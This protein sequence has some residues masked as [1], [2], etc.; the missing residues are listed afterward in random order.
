MLKNPLFSCPVH[1]SS[2]ILVY[3]VRSLCLTGDVV[4]QSASSHFFRQGCRT[5]ERDC[6][7]RRKTKTACSDPPVALTRHLIGFCI[8]G[9]AQCP[10]KRRFF[11]CAIPRQAPPAPQGR[12]SPRRCSARHEAAVTRH[13]SLPPRNIAARRQNERLRA[14]RSAVL[15]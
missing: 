4:T 1:C 2:A 3:Q 7:R 15:P 8:S 12:C 5:A 6:A 9:A 13:A 11:L 10:R 14:R